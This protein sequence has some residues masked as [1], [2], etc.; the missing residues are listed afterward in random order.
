M[1]Q[2]RI[3]IRMTDA[4]KSKIEA[5][6]RA[7][8]VT[9]TAY[10]VGAALGLADGAEAK[11]AVLEIVQTGFSAVD[12]RLEIAEQKAEERDAQ[13]FERLTSGFRAV[14]ERVEKAT[15]VKP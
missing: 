14:L 3:N 9:V 2:A 4:Q 6:A 15:A 13:V 11:N 10:M 5:A 1:P 7:L 12:E 8:G